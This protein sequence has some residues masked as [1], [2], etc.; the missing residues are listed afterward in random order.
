MDDFEVLKTDAHYPT[1]KHVFNAQAKVQ[2]V[3]EP[4]DPSFDITTLVTPLQH[5]IFDKKKTYLWALS[6]RILQNPL[7]KT[8]VADQMV[9]KIPLTCSRNITICRPTLRHKCTNVVPS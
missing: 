6:L 5:T 3:D 1:W 7:G 4:L 8:C 9:N 2:D